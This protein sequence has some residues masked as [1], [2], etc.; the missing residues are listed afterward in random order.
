L[1]QL[2]RLLSL[3]IPLSLSLSIYIYVTLSICI[4]SSRYIH[5]YIYIHMAPTQ[6]HI[7]KY[8]SAHICPR[9]FW[10]PVKFQHYFKNSHHRQPPQILIDITFVI[11]V[12]FDSSLAQLGFC[13]RLLHIHFDSSRHVLLWSLSVDA[14][15]P[16]SSALCKIRVALTCASVLLDIAIIAIV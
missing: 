5:I 7:T 2:S 4:S 14:A 9:P 13:S 12:H 15:N 1:Q 6:E 11:H 10:N 16:A 3:S 8:F